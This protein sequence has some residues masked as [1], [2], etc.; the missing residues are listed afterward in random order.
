M[1]KKRMYLLFLFPVIFGLLILIYN[2]FFFQGIEEKFGNKFAN[3][4]QIILIVLIV[5]FSLFESFSFIFSS[6]ASPFL[7][8]GKRAK[9][10]IETG[11]EAMAKI[12]YIGENSKGGVVTINDQP[13]LNLKLKIDDYKNPPYEVDFNTIIP[14]H[15]VPQFQPGALFPVKIDPEDPKVVVIDTKLLNEGII[16]LTGGLEI[17]NEDKMKIEKSGIAGKVKLVELSDTGKSENF[18]TIIKVKWDIS[19]LSSGSYNF[20][21]NKAM[22]SSTIDELKKILNHSFDAKIH[23]DN[24]EIIKIDISSLS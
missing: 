22:D 8:S 9:K 20:T 5:A 14:R 16:Y 13:Y 3:G 4:L 11:R 24:K 12:I 19:P 7:G 23:P 15:M 2:K 10:I 17:T 1:A 18:K 6:M 21:Y